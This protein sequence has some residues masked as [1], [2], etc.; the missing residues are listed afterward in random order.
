MILGAYAMVQLDLIDVKSIIY[1]S[2]NASG[3]GLILV[4]QVIDFNLSAFMIE[5]C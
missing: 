5:S 2:L 4:S 1:S 3:A